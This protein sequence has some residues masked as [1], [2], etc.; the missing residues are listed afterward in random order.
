MR[1]KIK[2]AIFFSNFSFE[3]DTSINIF[4]NLISQGSS[5]KEEFHAHEKSCF[6]YII[7][8]MGISSS[9]FNKKS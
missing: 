5:F 3:K 6:R 7:G 4:T 1:Y 9:K 8:F 2:E